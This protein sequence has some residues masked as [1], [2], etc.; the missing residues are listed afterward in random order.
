MANINQEF[1]LECVKVKVVSVCGCPVLIA[2]PLNIPQ[3][4]KVESVSA[5]PLQ[6]CWKSGLG[7][8]ISKSSADPTGWGSQNTP[9]SGERGKT[10][11]TRADSSSE[12]LPA[13]IPT[14]S[15]F[16]W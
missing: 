13:W 15:W 10:T 14:Q 11:P 5:A 1:N 4:H 8:Q 16:P 2:N 12:E 9:E 6:P 7:F 3:L